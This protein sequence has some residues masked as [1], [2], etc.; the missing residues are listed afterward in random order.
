MWVLMQGYCYMLNIF[1]QQIEL[2]DK[3]ESDHAKLSYLT[4]ILRAVLQHISVISIE[5]TNENVSSDYFDL[6]EYSHRL[7]KPSDGHPVQILDALIPVLRENVRDY[8]HGWFESSITNQEPLRKSVSE[9]VE[10]RNNR[11]GHGVLDEK[12]VR[13]WCEKS[14]NLIL[15]LL[16]ISKYVWPTVTGDSDLVMPE[17]LGS[18]NLATPLV[19]EGKAVV[20][21]SISIN[22]GISKLKGQLLCNVDAKE[23][24]FELPINNVYVAENVKGVNSYDLA[25]ITTD[26]GAFSIFHNIPTR[27]TDTFEGRD[28][29]LE[30]LFDW[31][32]DDESNYCLVFG[33]GGFGKTTLVLEFLNKLLEGDYDCNPPQIISYQTAK[34]TKWTHNGLVHLTG[35]VP[36]SD[37]I[38]RE[39]MRLFNP[40]L[41]KE[42][43][44]V[45]GRAL[46]DKA[47]AHITKEG[48]VRND[49]LLIIDNTEVFADSRADV[50]ELGTFFKQLGKKLGR[51]ILTSRRR[52]YL[53]ANPVLVEG[54]TESESVTLMRRLAEEYK[55][56]PILQAGEATLRKA[57]QKLMCKPLLLSSITKHISHTQNSIDNTLEYFF[58]KKNH[59]LL[60]FLYEDAW[61]RMNELQ[62]SAFMTLVNV[63]NPID[64]PAIG[65]LCQN[66][67]IQITELESALSETYFSN[68]VDHN[69]SSG[70]ELVP[71]AKNFF[72]KCFSKLPQKTKDEIKKVASNVDDDIAQSMEINKAYREDRVAEAFRT[73]MAKAAKNFATQGDIEAAIDMYE[74]AIEEDPINAALHDRFAWLLLNRTNEW[75][76]ARDVAQEAVRLDEDNCDAQVSLALI[77]YRLHDIDNGDKHIDK[78]RKLGRTMAFCQ[79][80]KGIARYHKAKELSDL[81][82]NIRTLESSLDYLIKANK[83]NNRLD[84]FYNKNS[85]EINKYISLVKADLRRKRTKFTKSK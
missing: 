49:I 65:F 31:L 23:V 68:E 30:D 79:L 11:P 58:S 14:R 47:E 10:Y 2:V 5:L 76:R 9:W 1:Y 77:Y 63:T 16:D 29:E 53:E 34:L 12:T 45:S 13:Q 44:E 24:V 60:D 6:P 7:R 64:E 59:E 15:E 42:W 75:E 62:K 37:E 57:A 70:I 36:A 81:S 54:L 27:Q 84:R 22:K 51:V 83:N 48:F 78:A 80:R 41:D 67:G 55:A 50:K 43:F 19:N 17:Y 85:A 20:I 3:E 35:V 73:D 8:L 28:D 39:L 82:K 40:R 72:L 61:G 38:V 52:E 66:V 69:G 25:E 32:T 21:R 56:K 26:R 74:L 46:I 18:F 33:D 4:S 71:L